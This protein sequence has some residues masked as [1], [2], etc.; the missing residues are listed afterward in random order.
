MSAGPSHAVEELSHLLEVIASAHVFGGM[1]GASPVLIRN[2]YVVSFDKKHRVPRWAA[3]RVDS[4]NLRT[5]ERTGKFAVLRNDDDIPYAPAD[6]EYA[7]IENA[8]EYTAE[9]LVPYA[10]MGGDRDG[11]GK[12]AE[13]DMDDARTIYEVNT[14]SNVVP[15]LHEG[16]SG[17]EGI[18]YRLEKLVLETLV[19]EQGSTVWVIAGTVFDPEAPEKLIG[20]DNDIHVPDAFFKVIATHKFSIQTPE[21]VAFLVPHT[22]AGQGE[23]TDFLVSIDELE[24]RTE[25]NFLNLLVDIDENRIE[26]S[27]TSEY[28][29]KYFNRR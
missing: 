26:A 7:V 9:L 28:W 3:Y 20:P 4:R 2:G 12:Y 10:A 18:W 25:L 6:R 1:P 14:M 8:G 16:F 21:I 22:S 13:N 27:D 19:A 11:D 23:I 17:P 29:K 5:P 15:M 24:Q